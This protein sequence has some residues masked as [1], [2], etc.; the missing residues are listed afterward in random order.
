VADENSGLRCGKAQNRFVVK[1]VQ[2]GGLGGLKIDR[3]SR[4]RVASTMILFRPL[5]A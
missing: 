1:I 5:S 3:G 2:T 4:R